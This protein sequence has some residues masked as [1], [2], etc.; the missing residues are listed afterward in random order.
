MIAVLGGGG[1]I[2]R[3]LVRRL[4]TGG[5][6]VRV[7]GR[8]PPAE[9]LPPGVEH[10][11]ADLCDPA[12]LTP[13]LEGCAVLVHL[14][15]T[16]VPG[17]A[18][19][20]P[21]ADARA[22]VVGGLHLLEAARAAGVRRV[23]FPSSGGAVYGRAEVTPTPE[24]QPLRPLGVYGAAKAA[25][26]AYLGAYAA[27]GGLD[28]TVLRLSN[29][30]GPG[31]SPFGGQG[32]VAA[33]GHRLLRGEPIEL[34]G[35]G[36]VVRDY[37][38]VDD[39]VDALETALSWT[40]AGF[41]VWNVGSGRGVSTLQLLSALERAAGARAKVERLPARRYDVPVSVLDCARMAARGWRARTS[42][43]EGLARTVSALR[44]IEPPLA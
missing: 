41:G 35:D 36:A 21:A 13:A 39:A 34:W 28:V 15:S 29:V 25:L 38:F 30:Y 3:A 11:R 7:L 24:D 26:E 20:D 14:A 18:G 2:G 12:G 19:S 42:L 1:F 17:T 6:A 5:A 32:A 23:V 9:P 16:S 10:R 33:F 31:Q 44:Q 37:L 27:A 4:A 22:N 8:S 43:E 40:D